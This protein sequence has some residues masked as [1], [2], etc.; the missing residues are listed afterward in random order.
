[1]INADRHSRQRSWW[2]SP[3]RN[4][5]DEW[6]VEN[7]TRR[8][9]KSVVSH[10]ADTIEKETPPLPAIDV[11][12]LSN[13]AWILTKRKRVFTDSTSIYQDFMFVWRYIIDIN[14]KEDTQLEATIT[15]YW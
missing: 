13:A 10:R 8:D 9:M 12:M 11:L 4:R 15:V 1:M 5:D 14:N 6:H 7:L 2:L 3:N